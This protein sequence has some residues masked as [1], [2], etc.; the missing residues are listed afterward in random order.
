VGNVPSSY[1]STILRT[2]N[3]GQDWSPDGPPWPNVCLPAG[4]FSPRHI[5]GV[6]FAANAN[7]G[8]A[9]GD[10]ACQQAVYCHT[11]TEVIYIMFRYNNGAW[12]FIGSGPMLSGVQSHLRAVAFADAQ[13]AIAVGD[14]YDPPIQGWGTIILPGGLSRTRN[15]PIYL[16]GVSYVNPSTA[17]VVGYSRCF[18]APNPCDFTGGLILR[19]TDGG[20]SWT[21][22]SSPTGGGLTGV[23]FVDANTGWAVGGGGA[24]LHTT[25]GGE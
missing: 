21:R 12:N 17:T 2:D 20:A 1:D 23:S 25:T 3:G 7:T 16:W 9:V 19:T 18:A 13:H 10:C 4:R 8:L 11:H 22:Q 15:A 24:I 14:F 6:S 5:Y